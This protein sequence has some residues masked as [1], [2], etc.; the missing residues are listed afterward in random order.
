M[1]FF[2]FVKFFHVE[3]GTESLKHEMILLPGHNLI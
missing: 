1:R 2:N 3:I